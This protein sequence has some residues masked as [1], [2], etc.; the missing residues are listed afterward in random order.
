LFPPAGMPPIAPPYL[1]VSDEEAL[2][3]ILTWEGRKYEHLREGIYIATDATDFEVAS[4]FDE[5]A[6]QYEDLHVNRNFNEE[7]YR[8]LAT[9]AASFRSAGPVTSALDFGSGTGLGYSVLR[10]LFPDA[11][12][13]A[14]DLSSGMA[15]LSRRA[16]YRM[17]SGSE[18]GLQT[19]DQTLDLVVGAF[20]LGLVRSDLWIHEIRR[21]LR[22]G[23]VASFNLYK[24][25]ADWLDKMH[26][27]FTDAGF[28]LCCA[29]SF[30]FSGGGLVRAQMPLI[31]VQKSLP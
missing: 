22:T 19:Q 31:V 30:S 20:V 27:L 13:Y 5:L 23:G 11:D 1:L 7:V 24:P 6:P 2:P 9:Q 18:N 15:A 29:D 16:G 25:S 21:V 10:K 17:I 8:V 4:L 28:T 3:Q 14:F 26:A 12:L